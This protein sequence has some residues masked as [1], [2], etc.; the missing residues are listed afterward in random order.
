[1]RRQ[2]LRNFRRD[3]ASLVLVSLVL[4][5]HTACVPQPLLV[6]SGQ[7]RHRVPEDL[8]RDF[9]SV[10]AARAQDKVQSAGKGPVPLAEPEFRKRN[11]E[12]LFMRGSRLQLAGVR[13]SKSALRKANEN[14]IQCERARVQAR[15]ALR[16]W[17]PPRRCSASLGRSL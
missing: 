16:M 2:A 10:R 15:A 13:S 8:H 12:N 4:A 7:A 3:P 17:N 1:V 9:P 11:L 6:R 14:F 5:P